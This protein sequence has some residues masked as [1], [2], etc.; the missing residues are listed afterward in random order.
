MLN[1]IRD[2]LKKLFID[3][4]ATGNSDAAAPNKPKAAALDVGDR[5]IPRSEK[6]PRQV[7]DSSF[8]VGCW[9]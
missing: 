4:A 1:L 5:A 9:Q 6:Q 8:D 7:I 2:S 3:T